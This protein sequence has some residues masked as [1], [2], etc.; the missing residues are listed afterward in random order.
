M[1]ANKPTA[2]QPQPEPDLADMD[3]FHESVASG[4]LGRLFDHL[5]QLGEQDMQE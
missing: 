2:P 3:A 4:A 1:P 5:G